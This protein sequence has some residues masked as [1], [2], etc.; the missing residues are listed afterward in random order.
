MGAHISTCH[1]HKWRI[2]HTRIPVVKRGVPGTHTHT[3]TRTWSQTELGHRSGRSLYGARESFF[4]DSIEAVRMPFYPADSANLVCF[5]LLPSN[6]SRKPFIKGF[7]NSGLKFSS[8]NDRLLEAINP[9]VHIING[10]GT[11]SIGVA[12]F[13]DLV[14]RKYITIKL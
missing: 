1:H 13:S 6:P 4:S 3:W 7:K 2:M 5:K 10:E 8:Q 12:R 11:Q 9:R 14:P